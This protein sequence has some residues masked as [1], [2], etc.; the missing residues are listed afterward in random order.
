MTLDRFSE[1]GDSQFEADLQKARGYKAITQEEITKA[2][3][4]YSGQGLKFGQV[5]RTQSD[6][7]LLQRSR[8]V[9]LAWWKKQKSD[10]ATLKANNAATVATNSAA[11]AAAAKAASSTPARGSYTLPSG[12]SGTGGASMLNTAYSRTPTPT[13]YRPLPSIVDGGHP[14]MA[15]LTPQEVA[16]LIKQMGITDLYA[17]SVPAKYLTSLAILRNYLAGYKVTLSLRT[18]TTARMTSRGVY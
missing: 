1:S 3:S 2:Y 18:A 13:T 10:A 11:A 7:Q 17:G 6:D 16:L 14:S 8:D 4:Q 12:G 9:V 5:T 15:V